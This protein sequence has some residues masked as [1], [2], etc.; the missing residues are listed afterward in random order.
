LSLYRNYYLKAIKTGEEQS[1]KHRQPLQELADGFLYE[2]LTLKVLGLEFL[3][4][5]HVIKTG[6][7]QDSPVKWQHKVLWF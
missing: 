5:S 6:M 3:P 2:G 1:G 7:L 4:R